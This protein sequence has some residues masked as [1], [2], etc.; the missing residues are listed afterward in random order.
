MVN[1]NLT[2]SQNGS[3]GNIATNAAALRSGGNRIT[4]VRK[5]MQ[6]K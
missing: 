2:N 5:P 3:S 1:F 4:N 6:L